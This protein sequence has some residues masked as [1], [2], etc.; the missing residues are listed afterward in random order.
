MMKASAEKAPG[1]LS[2]S[3]V[4]DSVLHAGDPSLARR[5]AVSQRVAG[6]GEAARWETL[7]YS[8]LD[9]M[10]AAASQR[11]G[12]EGVRPG[13]RIAILAESSA[14]WVVAFLSILRAGAVVVP[15]DPK[16][17]AGELGPMV[18]D[19][20]PVLL[21]ADD[22]LLDIADKLAAVTA[23]VRHVLTLGRTAGGDRDS[24][25]DWTAGTPGDTAGGGCDRGAQ[26]TALLLY[27][28][29]TTGEPKGV[30]LALSGL[31]FDA[32]AVIEVQRAKPEDVY[33]SILPL[34]HVYELTCGMLA[35]LMAGAHVAYVGSLFPDEITAAMRHWR[36]TH[37]VAVPLF[38]KLFKRGIE[39]RIRE[40]APV[41]R[42]LFAALGVMSAALQVRSV[43]H[44][45]FGTV[46]RNLG[47]A[48]ATF[49]VGGAP[50]DP[51]VARFF[52]NLGMGVYQGYGLTETSPVIATCTPWANETGS[53][54]PPLPG[55]EVRIDVPDASGEGEICCRGPIVMQG[56]HGRDD[57]TA[58]VVDGEGWF[59]TGDLGRVDERGYLWVTGRHKNVIVLPSGK[60]VQPEEL[61]TLLDRVELIEESCV[62]STAGEHGLHA[63][64]EVVTAVVVPTE[65]A[66]ADLG[67]GKEL[68][69]AVAG[70][71]KDA[72]RELAGFKRP[73]RIM[74]RIDPMEKTATR[75]VKRESVRD[76]VAAHQ[77]SAGPA[78]V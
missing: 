25:R 66:V 34:N 64:T 45:L 13:D 68:R 46:H 15:L 19:A 54:G 44:R 4:V 53:V 29:G 62:L 37:L 36:G 76:W 21:F 26:E 17:T 65:A 78:V 50:L 18:A 41:R 38:L 55:V 28:S 6:E 31:A 48:M 1:N 33:I 56:Y 52:E 22:A 5:P 27:T 35:P 14:D 63:G 20:S 71:A 74:V 73:Q 8:Q 32:R 40:G 24:L 60:N 69:D 72:L 67:S 75:K 58:E 51:E 7:N 70:A 2:F 43:R 77:K 57:L 16:L 11:L 23:S 49:F 10:T 42:V 30:M 59:H 39:R 9:L 61:E 47:G 3:D 12:V